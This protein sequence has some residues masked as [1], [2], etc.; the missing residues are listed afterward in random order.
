MTLFCR[1]TVG[2]AKIFVTGVENNELPKFTNLPNIISIS[3]L[4]PINSLIYT[5]AVSLQK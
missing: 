3:E 4:F 5:I 2:M 1:S